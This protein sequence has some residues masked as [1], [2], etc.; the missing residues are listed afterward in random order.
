MV[1]AEA[2]ASTRGSALASP[3]EEPMEMK[4][5]LSR[6]KR[7]VPQQKIMQWQSRPL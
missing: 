1:G 2:R 7:M 6:C 3:G 4:G 5:L